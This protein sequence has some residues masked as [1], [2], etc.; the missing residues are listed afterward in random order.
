M[1]LDNSVLELLVENL[2][3]LNEVEESDRLGVFHILGKFTRFIICTFFKT[4]TFQAFSRIFSVSTLN[5]QHDSSHRLPSYHGSSTE[6]SQ[7]PM[8]KIADMLQRFS[9]LYFRV[10]VIID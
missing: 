3:R 10:T 4:R 7:R 5:L 2:K 9:L 6:Y 1:Q 8:M